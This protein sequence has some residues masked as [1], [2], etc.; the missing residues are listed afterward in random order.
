MRERGR[1]AR[2]AQRQG[3]TTLL[4]LVLFVFAILLGSLVISGAI[5][6]A[7]MRLDWLP[8]P[9]AS[10]F[11]ALLIFMLLVSLFLGT[12]MAVL[13]GERF[14]RPLRALTEATRQVAAGNFDARVAE[15][16]TS[17]EIRRLAVSFNAMARELASIET[18]RSDFVSNISHEFKT[19][20]ASIR[21]FARRLTKD[22]LTDSQRR[23]YVDIIIAE[24]ERLMRLSSNVLLLSK[25]ESER[26]VPEKAAYSLDEQIRKAILL[27]SPQMEKKR[28][29]LEVR[30]APVRIVADEEM[31]GHLWINVLG[32]AIKFSAE[33]GHI[34]VTLLTV[35]GKAV[36]T[37][38]DTGIGMDEE[39]KK[40]IFDKFYQGDPS[41][42]TEGN[43]L[44]LALVKKIL[45]L[46]GG[47]AAIDS[48]PGQGTRFTVTLPQN[49]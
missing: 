29:A 23:E 39:T 44:G 31:I 46:A 20:V 37:I 45:E 38:A 21:G 5:T 18:L 1:R 47:S 4:L 13:A 25:L 42:A 22:T 16:G 19:P 7:L 3:L 14:L 27:L 26:G 48:A 2:G 40:Y 49:G 33:G 17:N 9:F 11:P 15:E 12:L 36:A 32:N 41:R 24:S 6:Y 10:R 30:L 8:S 34:A 43:G 28:L 35:G